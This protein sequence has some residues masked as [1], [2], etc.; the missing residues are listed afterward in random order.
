MTTTGTAARTI[1]IDEHGQF[2]CCWCGVNHR[3]EHALDDWMMHHCT[4]AEPLLRLTD[5]D[6]GQL[7]CGTCG[8][9]FQVKEAA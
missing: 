2:Y 5:P 8:Q 1:H 6:T 4:H 9:V 3:G 7:L